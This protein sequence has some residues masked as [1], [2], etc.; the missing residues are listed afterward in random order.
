MKTEYSL[1]FYTDSGRHVAGPFDIDDMTTDE[2]AVLYG[3]Y[4]S[5]NGK[6]RAEEVIELEDLGLE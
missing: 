4:S 3:D 2:L 5:F 6:I 1:T